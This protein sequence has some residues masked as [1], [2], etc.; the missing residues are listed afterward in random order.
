M[1]EFGPAELRD[2]LRDNP[3]PPL[4]VDVREPWEFDIC[5]LPGTQL[6]PMRQLFHE[7]E[8][9]LPPHRELVLICHHGIRSRQVAGF[10]ER[11]GFRDI[12]NLAGGLDAWAREVDPQMAT[13]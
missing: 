2:Y 1:R 5:R 10:L 6:F 9:Q 11:H 8:T 4:L 12:I 3:N 13:Y 7:P